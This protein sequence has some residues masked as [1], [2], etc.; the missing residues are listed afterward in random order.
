MNILVLN[1]GSSSVKLQLIETKTGSA[2]GPERV[3]ARGSVERVG[4]AEATLWFELAGKPAHRSQQEIPD[5]KEAISRLTSFLEGAPGEADGTS[6][7]D[8]V[9]HRMVHGGQFTHSVRITD[10]VEREIEKARD[11]APLHIPHNLKGYHAARA[12]FPGIPQAAVF[13]T[14]FHHSLPRRAR[15]YALPYE[16]HDRYQLRRVGYHGISH[17]YLALRYAELHG[18][19]PEDFKLITVHLG[20]GCS[21]CAVNRGTSVDTSLGF[22]PV[23][24]LVMGT[25]PGDVDTA[26]LLHIMQWE[27]MSAEQML[28]TLHRRSGLLGLSGASNDM[29][30]LEERM[31]RGDPRAQLAVEVFCYRV[32]KYLGAYFGVL[33]GADAVIFSGG[34]GE[35]SPAVRAL[36]CEA[37]DS[38]GIRLDAEKNHAAVG[39]EADISAEGAS[40][41]VWVIPTREELL[42][43]RETAEVI[44]GDAD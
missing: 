24:G 23:E 30:D 43:A 28:D 42:I 38:L 5:H 7:I 36:A 33:N 40:T 17:R 12:L 6:R 44:M 18:A 21:M 26:A 37:L 3:L 10:E 8:G 20:S 16:W 32:K 15:F 1:C 9:G 2:Q 41:R 27:D 14:A 35:N 4:S 11:L 19:R 34:I 39:A 13:D 25:R 31:R 29:R 22:S